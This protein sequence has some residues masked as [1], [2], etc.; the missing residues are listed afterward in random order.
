[1]ATPVIAAS[2]RPSDSLGAPPV[3]REH[4][5]WVMLVA[6]LAAGLVAAGP[7]EPLAATA[8]VAAA[9]AAFLAQNAAALLLRPRAPANAGPWLANYLAVLVPA[10]VVLLIGPGGPALVALALPGAALLAWHLRAQAGPAKDRLDRTGRGQLATAAVLALSGPAAWAVGRGSLGVEA[11]ALWAIFLAGFASGVY[12]VNMRLEAVKT[13]AAFDAATR[14]RLGREVVVYH[15]AIGLA[16]IAA[17]AL[18]PAGWMLL[19]AA[20]PYVVRGL[21]AAWRLAPGV[22]SFKRIGLVETAFA[23]WLAAWA[24]A[25]LGTL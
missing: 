13:R 24:V 7:V 16:A 21:L 25:F 22:P 2:P 6:P 15:V 1:M 11:F 18:L 10:G 5:A 8:L 17:A 14:W 4:G 19:A 23:A 12:H 9:I 3:P 20:A